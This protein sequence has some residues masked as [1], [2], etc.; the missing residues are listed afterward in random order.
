[1]PVAV[2]SIALAAAFAVIAFIAAIAPATPAAAE[3]TAAEPSPVT[4]TPP[5]D[6]PIS[7][8][9]RAPATPYGPGHR[10][11]E[12]DTAPGTEVHASAPGT[13]VFAGSVAGSRWVTISHRDGVRTTYGP[14]AEV[15]VDT[16][17]QVAAGA[18]LGATVQRLLLTARVAENYVDP[19]LLLSTEQ[20]VHLVAE[21]FLLPSIPPSSFGLDDLLSPDAIVSALTWAGEHA[22]QKAEAVYGLTPLPIAVHTVGALWQWEQA[23]C[24]E[25]SVIPPSPS[26]TLT[27]TT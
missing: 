3:P 21:P 6:A 2:R 17:Q 20:I 1:V 23:D 27:P 16:G 22:E 4:Y 19:A 18:V 25:G 13:V 10:G 12:Y 24:T 11:I 14:L 26:S 5:V 15:V 8:P 7:D 9:F